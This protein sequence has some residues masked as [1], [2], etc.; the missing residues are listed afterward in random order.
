MLEDN[1]ESSAL[2]AQSEFKKLEANVS[3]NIYEGIGHS[4]PEPKEKEIKKILLFLINN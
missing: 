1:F 2:A 4:I 3:M